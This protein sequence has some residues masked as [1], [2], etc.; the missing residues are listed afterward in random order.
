[1]KEP[2]FEAR[3]SPIVLGYIAH[4]FVEGYVV[5][6]GHNPNIILVTI[7]VAILAQDSYHVSINSTS[8]DTFDD[9]IFHVIEHGGTAKLLETSGVVESLKERIS[10]GILLAIK[11]H[12]LKLSRDATLAYA[13]AKTTGSD[14]AERFRTKIDQTARRL[15]SLMAAEQPSHILSSLGVRL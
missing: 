4:K 1:M 10:D 15:G 13:D 14:K 7:A 3:Y 2:A 11:A 8:T 5:A 6:S 12:R 9:F